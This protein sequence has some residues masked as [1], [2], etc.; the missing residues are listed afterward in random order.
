MKP[1]NSAVDGIELQ[2]ANS[3]RLEELQIGSEIYCVYIESANLKNVS[4][5]SRI[6][7]ERTIG[8]PFVWEST[9]EIQQIT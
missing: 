1:E 3:Y 9:K 4:A 7:K 5:T 8:T 2:V 6:M